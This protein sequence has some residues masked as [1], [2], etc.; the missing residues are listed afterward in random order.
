MGTTRVVV[1]VRGIN[2]GRAKQ[3]AMTDLAAAVADAG[4]RDVRTYLRSGN[5]VADLPAADA[6]TDSALARVAGHVETALEERT[7]VSARVLLRTADDVRAVVAANP[8]PDLVDRPKQL[9]VLFAESQPDPAVV[10]ALGTRHGADEFTVGDR[11]IYVAYGALD[12]Q[13]RSPLHSVLPKLRVVVTDRNWTT[14]TNLVAL[15]DA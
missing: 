7:G 6:R 1:L 11:A 12:G 2:L 13:Q 5:A 4:G 15:A 10:E 3:V 8:F 9:H 14:V